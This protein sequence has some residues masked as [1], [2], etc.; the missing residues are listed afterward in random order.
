MSDGQD[1]NPFGSSSGFARTTVQIAKFEVEKFNGTNNFGMW[2]CE[3]KDVLAQQDLLTALGEKPEAMSKPEWEK[4][5]LWACSSIRLCLAKTQKYFVIRETVASV[6][7]QKLEDKYMTKSA[8]NRLH[9]KKKLYRF[10]YKEDED[11][12]DEDKALI[13]LNSLPDSYEHFV[14]TI[15][16]G[17]ETVKFEDVSNALMNYEMRH[18]DKNH[19]STSEALFVRDC[20]KLKTKGKE[21][22]EANVAEVETDFSDFALTTSSSFDCATKWVLDTGCTHH[23]T[24]HK[25]WFSSLKEFDGGVVFMGDDNPCT[26]KGIGTV[27]LKLHDGMVKELTGVRYVPNLKKNLISLGTLESKGFRFHSDG[28]TLKVTYGALVVMKAPRC[29]HLYLLQGSTVTGEASVVSENMGTSDSDTTRLWHM[30]LGHAGEK[31]LQGLVKQGLLKGATTCKLDFC[32]HCVLGKQTR[33]KFGTVVHQTKGILDYVHSDVWGPTKTPSLSGRHWFVTFVDDY[34]R[35]SWVYTMKHKSEVLSIFLGWKKMVENQTGRKIKILRSD[36]GGEYT[37]DPFFKVCKEEGIV[38]H[39]SVQGTPQQNGVA[40]RLNRTLLEKVRCMLSQ[41]GLSKSFWAEA[42]NY[43]CHIINRLPSAVVQGKTPMELWTG[44]T[45]SDYD[46]IRIFG[47]PAYFH[48][49]EN[50]LDARAKKAIFLG[51]SSGVKGYR[52]WC[53]EMKKLVVSRDV[54]FDEESMFKDSEKNV[55]DVQQVELEKV[56]SGTSNPIS[57]DVEATTSEEVGD[58][59]DVEEVEL[60]DSIQVEEQVSPQESIAKNRGKRQITKPAR[61]SDYVSFALPIITDEI[62]SNFEEA[63]ESEEKKR[64][65]NAMG[66]EMNSLLKNKTWELAKLPK[67]KKAIGCKWV[68]AKKED[69]D[70]K[71]NVRF[72][73]RLVAKGYAQKEG[74]DYNEIFSPVV[75]HSSIR[76]MLALVAQYDLELVQLDV[77]TAFLHGDL[78]EEIYMCQ[79][80]GYI[81]KGKENLFCKLKKSLYGLKQS[82]RQWYLR[83]DKFMRGQN[84]S[85]SQ[86]DHCVYFKKLQDGSFIYLLIYVD[87]MLIASKNVEEIEKLKKQMKNE[88]EMK[89]LGKAKKILG[90]EI[91]RD[92]EKGLVSL[93]Q[94]QYLEKLIRKFGV[95]DSTK[96]V[97]T[98]LAP[99]FK[100]SSLQCPK[101]DKEKLQMKNIPYANLVGSLM[102][103]M[104]CSRPDIAHAVGM[105]SRYMHNPGKEHWQAAKW[106]L[107]YLHGT[108][109]VGLCFER[110]DSGIGHFAVGYVDSDYAGDLDGRKSTTGYV[111]TMAKG[112]VCWRSILQSSVALSTTEAEYM[113]VAEAIKEAI[114]IHGLIRDLGV[115][116]KQVE[117]HCDSQSAIYLAKYQVHHARTKH[118]D[119]RYHFVR[120]IVGE[121]E[122]IL[123]KIPTKDN[124]ADMLTK[125]VGVAKFVHCLNLAHIMPI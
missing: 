91:T 99:H 81:V 94:R 98:P 106:I 36:N 87:D 1:E 110:D 19:D 4:L 84:Y 121:G 75:K 59:E 65:C 122:I 5:N 125:V 42:V 117:V 8:E 10:Q 67:G 47:S 57:A 120:E 90:I 66:D 23:M 71:R 29:G 78:N 44:K 46:Y 50:K 48:V 11:I 22:S 70:E 124:P 109:D 14:T 21:S 26:T 51:F 88:F 107:R 116:Q 45:S 27:R 25:D 82:P 100:L 89:D 64:W 74:I 15:M 114:W 115:D 53:P 73:A 49:T 104:V 28:Q 7:W 93:N 37:S 6:L 108:R 83:F 96:P 56:A 72:K 40:E 63:I 2:Q 13:L 54:T 97:S 58:H 41:S 38:R 105:V 39:F 24:P 18:R 76:I 79:P 101:N 119:V 9:L 68:Y 69:A 43:A 118:I 80:D 12:K 103:A 17:K 92:R 86:Y 85:R 102:Y 52:L 16:H 30:R 62:P 60:E 34:S 77:K 95:H 3:V 31:A 55:K 20:P 32:E 112:P 123:Q 33:V 111:F 61:Y 35:R 113:A